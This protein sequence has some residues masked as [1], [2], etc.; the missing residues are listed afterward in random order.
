MYQTICFLLVV[1]LLQISTLTTASETVWLSSLD[2]DLMRQGWGAPQIDRSIREKPLSI[3]G[4]KFERGV[5]THAVSVLWV[6]LAGGTER[7]QASVGLDDAAGGPGSVNFKIYGDGKLLWES[8]LMK[9]GNA[10]K[11]I[12]LPLEGVKTLLLKVDAGDDDVNYDHADWAE[13][14]FIVSGVKPQ[15]SKGPQEEAVILTPKPGFSPRINGPKV[16]GC[17]PGNPF[18][19]RTPVTGKRPV[20]FTAENL[21]RGLVLDPNTGVI[22]GSIEERGEYES[23]LKASNE[24]GAV[25]KK[26]KIVC[27]DT[28]ALTPPMGWNHWYAHYARITDQ[29]MREA[30]DIMISSGMADAGYQYVNID[31][32]WM[33]S[34]KNNDPMREGAF[35]DDKGDIIPNK[36]FPDMKSLTDYIHSKGLKSGIYSSPGPRTCSGFAGSWQHEAQD[37]R[38]FADW[39]FDF[40]KYDWC[41]YREIVKGDKTLDALKKPYR[42]MGEILKKE[43][44]DIVFNLCQYGMGNV[45]E[46]GEEAGGHCWRTSGDLGYHL[47]NIFGVALK[48]ASYRAYSHPG[49]WNDPDYIQIGYIGSAKNLGMPQPCPLT[50]N[51]QYSFMSLWCLMAAPLFYSGDMTQLDEFTLNVL[52]NPEVIE[53]NQDPLGQ[54]AF[55]VKLETDAF[56]MVKEIKDG[57]RAVGLC[58]RGE[59]E[60]TVTAD[61]K[62]I[63][64]KGRQKARDLWRQKDL[65]EFENHFQAN[66]PRHGVVFIRLFQVDRINKEG[67]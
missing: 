39:G 55:V 27:G 17:R 29:M 61:W 36:H 47:D 5:G 66:V 31:D 24:H 65:G 12:D 18:L 4:K 57:S 6:D 46:W 54:C 11:S 30:A 38:Q 35:R 52:C 1:L 49:S 42:L 64:V 53:V 67:D 63:G 10:Y 43:K 62:D 19:Y 9:P 16:Y 34:Q 3:G 20:Q 51:E 60:T 8:G 21:P 28:L 45:W 48:N 7:F 33:N 25:E 23:V 50:P 41:S 22:T 32:C 14:R 56:V 15:A 2:L 37:A 26:F 13:A 44:R 40:L 59:F 58:N